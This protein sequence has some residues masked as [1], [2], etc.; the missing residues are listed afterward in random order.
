MATVCVMCGRPADQFRDVVE[1]VDMNVRVVCRA[2]DA[3]RRVAATAPSGG[4]NVPEPIA[5]GQE[6]TRRMPQA[7]QRVT[8]QPAKK[9]SWTLAILA[10]CLAAAAVGLL[11]WRQLSTAGP[12]ATKVG[13]A[14]T[15]A[16]AG[17]LPVRPAD[18]G[19]VVTQAADAAVND[20]LEMLLQGEWVHPLA[21]PFREL[22]TNEVQRFGSYRDRDEFFGRF[23]GAGHCG[24][25]LGITIGLPIMA[26]RDGV[27]DRVVYKP[28]EL[29]GKY[30][31]LEHPGNVFTY[32]MHMD[33]VLPGLKKGD[34]VKA[35]T[36]I[37][38]LG[39]TGIK[40]SAAHLHFMITFLVDGKE[41]YVD[42][43]PKLR[44]ARLIEVDPIPGWAKKSE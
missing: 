8:P 31:R 38:T 22:P 28:T 2:C 15:Q 4:Q 17:L 35:G 25:D 33:Q 21:G 6:R 30:I 34:E 10:S 44:D 43:E 36:M 39:R 37:G 12:V 16:D 29:E 13:V 18:A 26:V 14:K 27:I 3:A 11:A 7:T 20:G 41:R 1:V 9:S 5:G 19:P 40:H 24:V 42:P 32:Y 23:C